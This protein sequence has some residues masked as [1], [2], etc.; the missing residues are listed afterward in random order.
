MKPA[1]IFINDSEYL[2][3]DIAATV[4]YTAQS[5]DLKA[6]ADKLELTI[7]ADLVCT[8]ISSG[9]TPQHIKK[10]TLVFSSENDKFKESIP[11]QAVS[12]KE[13]YFRRFDVFFN[14]KEILD[15]LSKKISAD[16]FWEKF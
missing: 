16:T 2:G 13:E 8:F 15:T 12:Q 4:Q 10:G 11:V 6:L 9:N 3:L 5:V 14:K 1:W 7:P